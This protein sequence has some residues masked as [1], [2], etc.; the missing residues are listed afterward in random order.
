MGD[1][2]GNTP[3]REVFFFS[4]PG[5]V[6]IS[7]GNARCLFDVLG[8]HSV[9][10]GTLKV[11][12]F[13]RRKRQGGHV[14]NGRILYVYFFSGFCYSEILAFLFIIHGISL[15]NSCSTVFRLG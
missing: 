10:K 8:G 4:S 12:V 7:T 3:C 9:V 1:P 15:V 13:H 5:R 14:W 6:A 2:L 11:M